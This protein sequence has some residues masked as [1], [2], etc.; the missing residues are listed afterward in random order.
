MYDKA[1]KDFHAAITIAAG[2]VDTLREIS[3]VLQAKGLSTVRD[4][5]AYLREAG[6]TASEIRTILP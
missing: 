4:R 3:A 2:D 6:F 1:L 5:N